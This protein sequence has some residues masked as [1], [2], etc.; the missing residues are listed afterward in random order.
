MRTGS[1]TAAV[2]IADS[3]LLVTSDDYFAGG[4]PHGDTEGNETGTPPRSLPLPQHEEL[5]VHQAGAH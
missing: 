5:F 2:F 3:I 4:V 1:I